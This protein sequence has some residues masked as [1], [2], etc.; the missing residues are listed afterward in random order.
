MVNLDTELAQQRL[1]GRVH[2]H[3]SAH[4]TTLLAQTA[5]D[6]EAKPSG[7]ADDENQGE[8]E[9]GGALVRGCELRRHTGALIGRSGP[10]AEPKEW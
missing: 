5:A 3:E 10:N 9:C 8:R 1:A 6:L 4:G 2:A 7:R